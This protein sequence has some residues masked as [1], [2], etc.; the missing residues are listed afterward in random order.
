MGAVG[1]NY[2]RRRRPLRGSSVAASP[3]LHWPGVHCSGLQLAGLQLAAEVRS[4]AACTWLLTGWLAWAVW[5]VPA[6]VLTDADLAS[7][8]LVLDFWAQQA[9]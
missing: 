2:A 4:V 3:G 5:V 8:Q 7:A 9:D 6:G 1:A